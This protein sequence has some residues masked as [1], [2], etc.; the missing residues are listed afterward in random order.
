[1][2]LITLARNAMNT[3]FELVLHGEKPA[4]LRAAGEAALVE[5]ERIENQISLFRPNS[6]LAR[7]NAL[8][9]RE[10]VRVSPEFFALLAHAQRLSAETQG[11]FDIT[12]APL[13]RCWGMLG[14]LG[15]RIPTAEELT[16]ARAVTGMSLVELRRSDFT[17]RF[18]REG[19]MLDPGAIGKGY[20][21]EMAAEILREADI[22][23][24][25]IHGGTS[26]VCAI[27][28]PPNADAW[29]VAVDT[30]DPVSASQQ[31]PANQTVNG[32]ALARRRY[33]IP[34]CDES[35]SVSAVSGKS[36]VAGG[37]TFGHVI[38]PRSGEPASHALLAAVVSPSATETDALS[39]AL[40][41]TGAEGHDSI[42]ELR[43]GLRTL[44]A[45]QAND[46]GLQVSAH[47][48]ELPPVKNVS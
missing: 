13:L 32:G 6:E 30:P 24:A 40:L 8:A 1:M 35:L 36:F 42:A 48:I 5:V 4:S 38:D 9:A 2:S 45:S 34:L 31:C 15:G 14:Q 33:E 3:R 16:Q 46:G 29:K 44:L 10:P 41:V 11:A 18:A 23:S 37:R 7:V 12:I 17:V 20:A 21:V 43:P 22:A 26:T 19:V 25:L 28:K 39:T 47:K 27:G